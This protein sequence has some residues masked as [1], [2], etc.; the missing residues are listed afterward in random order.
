VSI[1]VDRGTWME[2][3]RLLDEA[4][5]LPPEQRLPWLEALA[6]DAAL[7]ER[8]RRLLSHATRADTDPFLRELP[9]VDGADPL[10]AG[11]RDAIVGP[12]RLVREIGKGGMASVWLAERNDGLLARPVALKLPHH[13]WRSAQLTERMAREREIL[14]ALNHPYIATL[15]DAGVAEDGQPFLALEFVEGEPIDEYCRAHTLNLRAR[16]ALF[17]QVCTAVAHAHAKLIVHRDLK[18]TNIL[19]TPGGEVRLLDFGIA[20]LLEESAPTASNLTEQSGRAMTPDYAAPEQILNE[21]LTVA[22]DIY[23]LGVVLY[24]LLTG[25]RP[26]KLTRDS[27]GALENA[28]LDA[29]PEKPSAVAASGERKALRGDLDTIVLKALKKNPQERYATVHAMADDVVRYLRNRP[30]LAQPDNWRYLSGKFIS[31][32]KIAVGAAATV[33]VAIIAGGAIAIWEA[34]TANAEKRRAEEVQRFLTAVL[35]NA[36]PYNAAAP[37][38]SVEQWLVQASTAIENRTDTR[39]DLRVKVLTILGTGLMNSQNTSAAEEVL[40]RAVTEGEQQL[41]RDDQLTMHARVE[42]CTMLRF[43]GRTGLLR[44]QLDE[45][46]PI[47][48]VHHE[49][50]PRDLVIALKEKTHLEVDTGHYADAEVAARE[51]VDAGLRVLGPDDADTIVAYVMLAWAAQHNRDPAYALQVSEQAYRMTHAHYHNDARHPRVIETERVL[52]IALGDA[53]QMEA[54]LEHIRLAVAQASEVFGSGSRMAGLS[55][56][57]LA[58]LE[59]KHGDVEQALAHARVALEN[60]GS[61]ADKK[62]F[63]YADALAVRG[64]ALLAAG[65]A[66]EALEDLRL[67][68]ETLTAT[69]GPDHPLTKETAVQLALAEKSQVALVHAGR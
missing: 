47:L 16:L 4:L 53:G 22:A 6:I 7:K 52:G 66:P 69:I 56:V 27:R 32:N 31:R 40:T 3:S 48:R 8:L 39:P 33:L 42:Y 34:R 68:T 2:L 58:R 28:I 49:D 5:D 57:S 64:N 59:L 60:V 17:L 21:P 36:D 35:Q 43:R 67:A 37:P 44:E 25:A 29:Q 18:P 65:H 55:T 1:D 51:G 30:V 46:L 15:Y 61:H 9:K 62:S 14:A 38:R 19:V 63:R 50:Y 10:L 24:E 54:G 20:K 12:Y 26:Y 11:K 41:G 13:A 45:L 23:S